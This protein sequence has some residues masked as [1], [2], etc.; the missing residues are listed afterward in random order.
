MHNAKTMEFIGL[1][2]EVINSKNESMVG[3]KG[4]VIDE[5]KDTLIINYEGKMKR[6]VKNQVTLKVYDD[7]KEFEIE[8]NLLIGRS[9]DRIKK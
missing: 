4:K 7:G 5:T 8:G 2:V 1:Y 3:L 6:L 9:E